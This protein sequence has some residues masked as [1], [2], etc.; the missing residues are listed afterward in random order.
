MKRP[1]RNYSHVKRA[2]TRAKL[3]HTVKVKL[4]SLVKLALN[5]K[6]LRNMVSIQHLQLILQGAVRTVADLEQFVS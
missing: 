3:L 1:H 5:R 2:R 4:A 6:P